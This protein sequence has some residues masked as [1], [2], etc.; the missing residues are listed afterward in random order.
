MT[1]DAPAGPLLREQ[2]DYYRARA[3]EYDEWWERRGRYD[4]GPEWNARWR[5]EVQ[6]AR[7]A[8]ARFRPAGEVL[9]LA[10]GTGWWTAE[11]ARYAD[12]VTA[13]DAS[14][15]TLALNRARVEG[16]SVR[17]VQAEIFS[18]RPDR[19]YD[20]VFFSFWLSHVPPE[21]FAAFW[22]TVRAALRPGGRVFFVDSLR[23]ETSTAADHQ[24]PGA[25]GTV[26]VRSLN[27]GR[28]FRIVKVFYDPAELR[29]RLRGLGWEVEVETTGEYFLVGSGAPA[30]GEGAA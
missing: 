4:H 29:A 2:I 19:R 8:L 15:E 18:W 30:A 7:D 12:R 27:D 5:G 20:A 11:L 9:E 10:C 28:S 16:A 3:G 14:P 1:Q 13:L 6:A 22:D 26:A 25:G 24:L 23:T 21:R 17:H